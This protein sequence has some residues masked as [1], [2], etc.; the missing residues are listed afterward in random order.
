MSAG[1]PRRAAG[2]ALLLAMAAFFVA[3]GLQLDLGTPR[4]MGPG[5]FP[6]GVGAILAVLA[7]GIIFTAIRGEEHPARPQW[8]ACI[9]IVGG[10]GVFALVVPALGL[11]PAAFLCV[12][13]TSLPDHRLPFTS[14]LILA[15]GVAALVWLVFIVGLRLPFIP[16][17]WP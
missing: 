14:K 16:F 15:A 6:I 5:F 4:R 11:L 7:L 17:R 13:V 1:A 9:A 8:A 10:L 2:G 3:G 12:L